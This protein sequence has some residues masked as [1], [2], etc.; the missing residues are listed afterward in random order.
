M[1]LH[2]RRCI[3]SL[4]LVFYFFII[5][6]CTPQLALPNLITSVPPKTLR[7]WLWP[8]SGLDTLIKAY[9]LKRP[10][11]DVEVVITQFDD[12]LPSLKTAFATNGD[13]PDVV[14]LESSQLNQIKHF[15]PYFYNLYDFNDERVHYLDWK[16]RQAENKDRTFLYGMPADIGPIALA[17]RHDLFKAAGLPFERE[18]VGDAIRSWDDLEQAGLQ[19]KKKTGVFLFDNLANVYSTYMNQF[20]APYQVPQ[21]SHGYPVNPKVK[22]AWDLAVRYHKLGI[23]AG[24]P[25]QTPGWA[26]GAVNGQFAAVLAPSWVHGVMK[27]NAPATSGKWDLARAPGLPSNWKGSFLAVPKLSRYPKEAYEL[28]HWLTAPQ[29]QLTN[30]L[31]NGNF[32]STPESYASVSFLEVRDPF[33]NGAPVGQLYSYP[34]LR[35]KAEYEE[36][37]FNRMDRIVRDGLRRVEMEGAD[38]EKVWAAVVM[39]IQEQE[40]GD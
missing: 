38:P 19:L 14:L 25:S 10:D 39:Q 11:I 15:Q 31:A 35:Y 37:E 18:D 7:I 12:M 26:E 13:T 36:V 33:F 32:P 28:A 23:N 24:L 8:G 5:S 16:W 20:D 40:E 9:T 30:F 1:A 6:A 3:L 4:V 21:D 29:Q 34:A 22:A 2:N 17:Y 27:K